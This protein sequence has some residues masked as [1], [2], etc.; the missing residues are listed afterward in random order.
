MVASQTQQQQQQEPTL[1]WPKHLL[2]G[3]ALGCF[4]GSILAAVAAHAAAAALILLAPLS[5]WGW[6][7]AALVAALSE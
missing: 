3:A 7:L 2:V 1:S 5:P 6:T 4:V